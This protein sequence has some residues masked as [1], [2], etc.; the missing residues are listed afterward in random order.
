MLYFIVFPLLGG[1]IGWV[2]NFLAIKFLFRPRKPLKLG[3]F[4]VQGVIPRRRRE[5]AKEVGSIVATELLSRDEIASALNSPEIRMRMAGLAGE[6]V[7]C[8]VQENPILIPFPRSVRERLGEMVAR[9]VRR[10]V[11]I[12]LTGRGSDMTGRVMST[13]DLGALVEKRLDAMEWDALESIVYSVVGRELR[14]IE[15]MGGALGA[16][17]GLAQALILFFFG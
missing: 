14:L 4:V 6:A 15:V 10:E 17:V 8:R 11:K 12:I 1:V 16:L 13:V 5:L 2:T 9:A 3:V 7:A